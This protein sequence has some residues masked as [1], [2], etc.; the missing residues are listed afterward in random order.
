MSATRKS[1]SSSSSRISRGRNSLLVAVVVVVSGEL[2]GGLRLALA[3]GRDFHS[4]TLSCRGGARGASPGEEAAGGVGLLA[5]EEER[6]V[7]RRMQ[8]LPKLPVDADAASRSRTSATSS[9][10]SSTPPRA[11]PSSSPTSSAR[12][13]SPWPPSSQEERGKWREMTP[14]LT[15]KRDGVR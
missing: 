5:E 3:V 11:S 9:A 12:E 6:M 10:P 7:G 14:H 8:R 1:P 4:S 15:G 2:E 13:R